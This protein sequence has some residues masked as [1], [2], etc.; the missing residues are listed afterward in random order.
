MSR[1]ST[2]Q[3]SNRRQN[4][5]QIVQRQHEWRSIDSRQRRSSSG[6]LASSTGTSQIIP[7]NMPQI[8]DNSKFEPKKSASNHKTPSSSGKKSNIEQPKPPKPGKFD[9]FDR[10]NDSD[11]DDDILKPSSHSNKAVISSD[12]DGEMENTE[13]ESPILDQRRSWQKD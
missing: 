9:R 11:S 13:V 2:A 12:S 6:K 4:V 3:R 1:W 10:G 5:L 7:Q 8:D